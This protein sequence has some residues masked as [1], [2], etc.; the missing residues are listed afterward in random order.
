[1]TLRSLFVSTLVTSALILAASA[2]AHDPSL[3]DDYV[4]PP[5]KAKPASCEQLADNEHFSNNMMDPDIKALKARCDAEQKDVKKPVS[6]NT[7]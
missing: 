3:H 6:I 5:V 1:M 2:S 4:P 7:Q